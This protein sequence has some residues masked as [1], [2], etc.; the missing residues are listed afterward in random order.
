MEEH[1]PGMTDEQ[2]ARER[3]ELVRK[4][5]L[6][7]LGAQRHELRAQHIRDQLDAPQPDHW[8]I[9]EKIFVKPLH[10][11]PAQHLQRLA[12]FL[13][14]R[15]RF[16]TLPAHQQNLYGRACAKFPLFEVFDEGFVVRRCDECGVD[17][18]SIQSVVDELWKAKLF[19]A[20]STLMRDLRM[21]TDEDV[22]SDRF[23]EAVGLPARKSKTASDDER[24][25]HSETQHHTHNLQRLIE[26][27]NTAPASPQHP[28]RSGSVSSG[29]VA[30]V[31]PVGDRTLL[32]RFCR[33]C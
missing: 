21:Y 17:F 5:E 16:S 22:E 20:G 18:G 25:S 31:A 11:D 12:V 6:R 10:R 2:L 1:P 30:Q 8:K 24:E 13:M 9:P 23:R 28:R 3:D 32:S 4:M 33:F 14:F 26:E 27:L 15:K 19:S 7:E 29:S